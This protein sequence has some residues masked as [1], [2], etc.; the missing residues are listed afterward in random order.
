MR[1]GTKHLPRRAI[2]VAVRRASRGRVATVIGLLCAVAGANAGPGHASSLVP[3]LVRSE[4]TQFVDTGGREVVLRGFNLIGPRAP[5][6]WVKASE[7]G[8]NFIRLPVIWS[9]IEP[10]RPVNGVHAWDTELLRAIDT[11]V[12]FHGDQ[13]IHVLIDFHQ[14]HWSPYFAAS[15][16]GIPAWFYAGKG[17]TRMS[18]AVGAWYTDPAGE[19][20]FKAFVRMMVT[21]YRGFANV[22]GYQVWNEPWSGTLGN[23]HGATQ[24]VLDWQARIRQEIVALDPLRTVVIQARGGGNLGLKNGDFSAFGSL[25]NLAVD[26]HSYF[27]ADGTGYTPDME[28]WSPS[29]FATHLWNFPEYKGTE[30][31]QQKLLLQSLNKTRAL[32][33]PLIVGEWG[34]PNRDRN[35]RGYQAQM[36]RVFAK[37][38]VSWTRWDLSWNKTMGVLFEDLSYRPQAHQLGTALKAIRPENQSSPAVTGTPRPGHQLTASEGTWSG[39]APLAYRY[40]WERCDVDAPNCRLIAA[41]RTYVVKDRDVGSA[42]RVAVTAWNLG[43]STEAVSPAVVVLP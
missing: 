26:L 21:R 39:T 11:Q 23:N 15:G 12:R 3:P 13:G 34:I 22:M 29:H 31:N 9:D 18:D 5:K 17:F 8:A 32:G 19:A 14:L 6:I 43:G 2:A 28:D 27:T 36:L 30:A 25:K 33:I 41:T 4:G 20:A 24:V 35:W 37:H 7:L 38:N 10:T 1:P 16:R 42:L 40:R